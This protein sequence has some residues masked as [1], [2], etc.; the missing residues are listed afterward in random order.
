MTQSD[1]KLMKRLLFARKD[2]DP[3]F[4]GADANR[5]I[6]DACMDARDKLAPDDR[7]E[8]DFVANQFEARLKERKAR[9]IGEKG[10]LELLSA[11]AEYL[12]G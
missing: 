6:H 5:M 1:M 2:Y 10:I 11:I 3:Q 8:L 12:E 7:H 9:E 4:T